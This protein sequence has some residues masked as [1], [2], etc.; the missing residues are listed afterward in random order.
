MKFI[1]MH[2]HIIYGIDDGAK[3]KQDTIDML[4]MA[5]ADGI[6]KVIFTPHFK[7]EVFENNRES[8]EVMK[9]EIDQLIKDN[10]L[11]I[12]AYY[13]SEIYLSYSSLDQVNEGNFKT[14]NDS[15]YVLVETHRVSLYQK[16]NISDILY[17]FKIDKYVPVVAH[18]ERY[19][20]VHE[21]PNIVYEWVKDGSLIQVNASSILNP[22]KKSHKLARLLLKH[23]LVHFIGSDA[24]DTVYRPPLLSDAYEFVKKHYGASY[25]D[26]LFYDNPLKVI[27]NEPIDTKGYKE[28]KKKKFIII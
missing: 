19:Q 6:E 18:P 28:I 16:V 7:E 20:M 2:N 5:I 14:L 3:T 17:N 22:K 24:H 12:D 23:R 27:N 15:K 1:D 9:T 4:K 10:D 13:G 21:D 25:A 26:T 11:S 8:I